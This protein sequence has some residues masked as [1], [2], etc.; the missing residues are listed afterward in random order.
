M[1][2]RRVREVEIEEREREIAVIEKE[3][4]R[5]RA[6]IRRFLA[7][8]QEERE[9]GDRGCGEDAGARDGR[10]RTAAGDGGAAPRPVAGRLRAPRLGGRAAEGD[11]AHSGPRR[12][13]S[14]ARSV[15]GRRPGSPVCTCSPSRRPG[16]RRPRRRPRPPSRGRG[17]RAR[18]SRIQAVGLER[19][20]GGAG[21]GGDG[22]REPCGWSIPSGCSRRRRRAW[23]RRRVR[24]GSTTR[25]PPSSSW[26]RCT[27][28]PSATC[29]SIRRGR[30]AGRSPRPRSGCTEVAPTAP[31]IDPRALH[32]GVSASGRSW[33]GVTQ[34]MPEGLRERLARN[35]VRGLFGRP[36]EPLAF[37][38]GVE[39]LEALAAAAL[40]DDRSLPLREALEKITAEAGDDAAARAAVGVLANLNQQG[41][42]RRRPVRDGVVARAG[43]G[44]RHGRPVD[45]PADSVEESS[46]GGGRVR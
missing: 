14:R 2:V 9:S 13:P 7:R 19:E 15:R 23:S 32:L 30:W 40:G 34:S 16:G 12:A 37:R 39:R 25:R 24:S 28:R 18:R 21:P 4:D 11:R 42:L 38:R 17:R 31:W 8:E 44:P 26:P 41:L 3:G 27:S 5:E 29:T 46:G 20:A 43:H 22:D 1:R 10:V 6:D 36:N 33:E 35:G 45:S